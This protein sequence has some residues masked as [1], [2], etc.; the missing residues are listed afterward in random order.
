MKLLSK[1][2]KGYIV[3]SVL[4]LIVS[5]PVFYFE[6]T[7]IVAE[8]VDED[9]VAQKADLMAKM[10]KVIANKPFEYFEVFEPDIHIKPANTKRIK[11]STYTI[12]FF[13]SISK[14]NVPHRVLESI[15]VLKSEWYNITI[16][17]SLVDNDNLIFSIVTVQA[18]ILVLIIVGLLF[19]TRYHSNKLWKPF[20]AT[21]GKLHDYKIECENSI[22]LGKTEIDEFA[23]L[24]TTITSLTSRNHEMYLSQKE[25]TENASH[26]MQTPL[27]VFQSKVELLMQTT[28][29]TGEQAELITELSDAGQRMNRLN[30]TLLL[31]SKIDNDQFNVKEIVNINTTVQKLAEQYKNALNQKKLSLHTRVA[32]NT[33]INANQ[34]LIEILIGNLVSNAIRHNVQGGKINIII[35]PNQFCISNTGNTDSLD[36]TCLFQRFQKQTSDANSLGLGLEIAKRIC[37]LYKAAITYTYSDSLH[38]FTVSFSN[39]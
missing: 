4:V 34:T 21:L 11:D 37:N 32:C 38:S 8:D 10:E 3:Y 15:V 25:F 31:L 9:L 16:R 30:K 14:E 19:I 28:P 36:A 5:V 33:V 29:L 23:D 18:V 20:Y 13:D 1:S 22:E 39:S 7:S 26:E 24:N 12:L 6:L 35:E 2:L 27:A 17:K